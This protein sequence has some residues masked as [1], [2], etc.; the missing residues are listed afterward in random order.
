MAALSVA[1]LLLAV[2]ERGH[3]RP[4]Q[5]LWEARVPPTGG[6]TASAQLLAAAAHSHH[7]AVAE[8]QRSCPA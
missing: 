6:A 8:D 7:V 2:V 5:L 1:A 3:G 4:S